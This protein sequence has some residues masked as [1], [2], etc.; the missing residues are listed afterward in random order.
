[1]KNSFFQLS[2][3]N[4]AF[5]P[6]FWFGSLFGI[7][8]LSIWLFV[9]SN[10]I[11][12][13]I[14]VNAIHWH[15]YEMVFGFTKAIVLGFLFTAVQNWTNSTILKGENLF[16]LLL[17]WLLGRFSFYSF[18]FL[19]YLSFGF[20]ICSDIFVIYLLYPKLIVPTQKHNRPILYHYVFFTIFHILSAISAYSFLNPEQTLLYI[21]LSIFVV[22][23]L[24]LII[25]GR[26]VPFFTGVVVQGYSFKRMPK[27]EIGLLYLPYVFY[28]TK[29]SQGFFESNRFGSMSLRI[30][31]GISILAL[32][33][34]L[35]GFLLFVANSIRYFSWKPWMSYQR[36]ILW[37]LHLGYFWVCLGFL[38]YSLSDLNLFPISSAI[39]CL[40]VG[41][42]GVFI[43]GMITRVS[44]GHTGR[45]IVASP[46]TVFAYVVLNLSVIFRVF[47]PLFNEYKYAYY[48]SGI[49]WIL[50]FLIFSIQYS[51]ILFSKRPDGKP[52]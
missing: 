47:L 38:F 11:T 16:Y 23:F 46:L 50:C 27:L 20:D 43:Y 21:H 35:I 3:W 31:N 18:G 5:R 51:L 4:T 25:G 10:I 33:S 1:M 52:S 28:V 30:F 12:N 26:V 6:F 39:H 13:P 29:W 32:V 44:L 40:T 24:I 8:I 41:G 7:I 19:G 48:L 9:L 37:I 22:L 14:Q 36:P 45:A 15:S 17:F 2:F 49:G 34:F 42:L